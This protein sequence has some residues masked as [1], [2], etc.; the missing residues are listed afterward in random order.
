M[1]D[2]P[3]A[4][5]VLRPIG[6]PL[7]VG[8]SGLAIASLVQS[9]VDLRWVAQS[10]AVEAGLILLAVP[11]VLQLL[12][13]IFCYLARDGAA[14]A[15]IGTLATTWLALGLVHIYSHGARSPALGLLLLAAGAVLALSAI[16]ACI[17]KPLPGVVFVLAAVRF[18]LSGIYELSGNGTCLRLAGI[19]GL[20]ACAA[21]FYCVIA[22]ELES[23]QRPVLPTFRRGPGAGTSQDGDLELQGLGTEAGVR[24]GS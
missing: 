22:F 7:T 24:R 17:A 15:A 23:Q 16:A 11:F 18:V 19:V 21:A 13:T 10:Q 6:S 2:Q 5:I 9:G 14:G 20:I 8:M 12:A 1:M 3:P 4:R